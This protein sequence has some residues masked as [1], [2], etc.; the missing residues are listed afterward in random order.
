MREIDIVPDYLVAGLLES[1]KSDEDSDR[2]AEQEV[3]SIW[4]RVDVGNMPVIIRL[5]NRRKS[6]VR[7]D[8]S[9]R[10]RGI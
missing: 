9:R 8:G 2:M 7:R 6:S 3:N 10:T 5:A 1:E 4:Q